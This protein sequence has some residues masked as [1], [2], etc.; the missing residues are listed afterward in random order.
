MTVITCFQER[1][2]KKKVS[3]ER[4]ILSEISL[5]G[6]KSEI[7]NLFEPYFHYSLLSREESIEACIDIAIESYLQGAEFSKFS[8]YGEPK[9][10]IKTRSDYYEKLLVGS[11]YEFWQF[12]SSENDMMMESLHMCCDV[13][14]SHWWNEGFRNGEKRYRM[15]LN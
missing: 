6:I 5:K 10:K 12:W 7:N 2:Q 3:F 8:Y 9:E 4:K 15:R 1:Q 14:V 13:F 11:L